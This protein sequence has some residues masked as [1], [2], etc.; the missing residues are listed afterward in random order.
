MMPH[1]IEAIHFLNKK[2]GP[3]HSII[4]HSLGGMSTLKAIKEGIS[5]ERAVIIGTANSVTA[6]TQEFVKNLHMDK[7]VAI[8]IKNLGRIWIITLEQF[9]R[10]VFIFLLW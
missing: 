4:G 9:Q 10:K 5:P 1:F 6:I 8:L 2:Y 7:E 3:F